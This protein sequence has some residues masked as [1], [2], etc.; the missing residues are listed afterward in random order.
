[1]TV[2]SVSLGVWLVVDDLMV[3][4]PIP[5]GVSSIGMV[6]CQINEKELCPVTDQRKLNW[7]ESQWLQGISSSSL[8]THEESKGCN[9]EKEKWKT[10]E[11]M[12]VHKYYLGAEVLL[13]CSWNLVPHLDLGFAS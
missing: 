6:S 2:D 3:R 4:V 11:E 5:V 1:V 7:R 8:S 13:G 9:F 12:E 10:S